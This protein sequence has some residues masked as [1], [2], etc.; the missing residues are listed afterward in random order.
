MALSGTTKEEQFLNFFK[1]KGLNNFGIAGLYGNVYCESGLIP[2][3]LQNTYNASLSMTDE[4]YTK[5]VDKGTYTNFVYDSAGYG[6]CQWTYWSRKKGLLDF[7]KSLDKSI[8]DYEMQLSFLYQELCQSYSNVVSVLKSAKSVREAS[9][10]VLLNFERP[11][12]QSISVQDRRTSEGQKFYDKYITIAVP[13]KGGEKMKYSGNNKPLQCIMTNSTCYKN[14]RTMNVK[15]ILWHSTGANNPT[16]RRYVQPN[17]GDVN[18]SG[19]MQKLG[20]NNNGNDWNHIYVEAGVNAWIGKLADES[21]TTVQTLPWNYRPWGCGDGSNGSCNDG[22]IQFEICED[23]LNDSAYFNKVYKEACELTAYLCKLYNINPLGTVKHNG[24][25]VPTILCHNDS[26]QLGLGSGHADVL[27]WFPKFGKNMATVRSDVAALINSQTGNNSGTAAYQ[28]R[29]VASDGLN[30]RSEPVTGDV[31]NTYPKGTLLTITKENSGWGYTGTG[32]VSLDW[33]Q[34]VQN[35]EMEDDDMLSFDDWKKY[36]VQYRKELQ[37]NDCGDWSAA[38]RDWAIANGLI[39]GTGK[40]KDG[41][42]NYAWADQL[43]R[44][45]AAALFYRFAQWMGKA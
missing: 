13:S 14:T 1:S 18:Y 12:D 38:A 15:G 39:S 36:M 45:Q 37:D 9:N 22:W 31:I 5:A 40:G 33:I 24:V 28:A 19:L 20:K 23:G 44:E 3:N 16:L 4:E 11:A 21:V 17:S 10:S 32:W 35:I 2:N 34:F 30:C 29:V 8:G 26:F 25:T 27:H 43:T 7:A 42:P 41:K 6:I